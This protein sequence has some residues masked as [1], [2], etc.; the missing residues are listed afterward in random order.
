[1]DQFFENFKGRVFLVLG[2]QDKIQ[3][4]TNFG[5]DSSRPFK[6]EAPKPEQ[7]AVK[8]DAADEKLVNKE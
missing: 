8:P 1:M 2:L 3:L 5:T 6:W 7:D 4:R